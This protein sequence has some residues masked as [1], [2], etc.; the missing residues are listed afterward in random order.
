[1]RI[2]GGELLGDPVQGAEG[3]VEIAVTAVDAEG[4]TATVRFRVHVEF[5]WPSRQAAGW[6]S[7]L[8]ALPPTVADE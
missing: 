6:R 2:G 5:H 3:E 8:E 7:A 4:L 1:M